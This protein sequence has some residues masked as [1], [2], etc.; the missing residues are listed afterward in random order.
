M[1]LKIS[2]SLIF[3]FILF[4][5]AKAQRTIDG[6]KLGI[7]NGRAVYLP[8]PEY[9]PEAEDFC[10]GGK[11]EIK[12]LI[13]EKGDVTQ[14]EA[15]SGDELLYKAAVEAVKKAKFAPTPEIAVKSR[16]I[17]VYNFD[18]FAKC[19]NVGVVNKKAIELPKPKINARIKITQE[20][21]VKVGIIIDESGKV[22]FAK[23]LTNIHP[24]LRTA[25]ES[26]ARQAKFYPTNDVGR[27]R[28]KAYIV[29]KLKL[30]GK[31]ET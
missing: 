23:V 13:S 28:I 29:Y 6:E 5:G 3:L 31:V 7:V 10:A 18:S 1:P 21:T 25:F 22:V 8:K 12:V 26:A 4:V 15:I 19:L 24:L 11:V 16:G 27:I 20:T 30:N 9:P 2:V 17:V 14:A